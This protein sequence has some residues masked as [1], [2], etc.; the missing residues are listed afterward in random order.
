MAQAL[1]MLLDSPGRQSAYGL[2]GHRR[3]TEDFNINVTARQW[4][5]LYHRLA[6][7]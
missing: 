4:E 1:I 2:A 5:S 7:R 6:T 3:V